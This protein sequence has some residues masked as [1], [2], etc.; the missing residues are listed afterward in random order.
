MLYEV[1]TR[2][3]CGVQHRDPGVG[4]QPQGVV[5][6]QEVALV[7]PQVAAAGNDRI[8]AVDEAQIAVARQGARGVGGDD[9]KAKKAGERCKV[10]VITSYSIHYTKL[11]DIDNQSIDPIKP[12]K[13]VTALEKNVIKPVPIEVKSIF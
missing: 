8:G 4:T 11:Y 10:S 13:T 12:A 9:G 2:D 3:E 1:I 5:G 6:A 7:D